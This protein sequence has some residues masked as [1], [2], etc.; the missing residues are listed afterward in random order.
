MQPFWVPARTGGAE[1]ELDRC[2]DCGGVWF[3]FGELGRAT[4]KKLTVAEEEVRR[5]CPECKEPMLQSQLDGRIAVETCARCHGTFLEARDLD[6]LAKG[7]TRQAP[8][9]T[10]FVCE[11]CGNRRPFSEANATL[12][13]LACGACVKPNEPPPPEQAASQSVFSRFVG[14]LSGA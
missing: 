9:G 10:G 8:G 11:A 14:W 2:S 6:M 5:R 3:D 4:G 7:S 12:T 1:L 13:G